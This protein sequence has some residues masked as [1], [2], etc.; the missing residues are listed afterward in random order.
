[1]LAGSTKTTTVENNLT[2][3]PLAELFFD[4]LVNGT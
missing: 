1:M 3:E 4:E 2:E